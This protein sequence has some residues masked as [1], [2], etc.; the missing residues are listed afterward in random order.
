MKVLE[1]FAGSRSFSSVAE[2]LGH[3]TFTV[4]NEPFDKIDLVK[5]VEMLE[6]KDIPFKPDL[7]WASPPCQSY[8]LAGCRH[9]RTRD[10]VA[11]SDF[12]KKSDRLVKKTIEIIKHFNC[13]YYIEN[14][15]AILRKMPFMR[16]IPK[17]TVWYCKYGFSLAKPTDIFTNNLYSLFNPDGWCPRSE[18]RNSSTICHHEP[19]PRG[20]N[21][22]GMQATKKNAYER[23][24]VPY[25]LCKEI[26]EASV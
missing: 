20:D 15:R 22:A 21:S 17:T 11:Y 25:Q 18:C 12:A 10:R 2:E 4:D 26:L 3:E 6:I 14:P 13:M 1:L 7:I 19:A 23:S 8:S 9:H 24:K 5:D 16:G